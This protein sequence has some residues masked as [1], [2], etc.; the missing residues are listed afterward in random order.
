M[1][2][3]WVN[4]QRGDRKILKTEDD[5]LYQKAGIAGLV[6]CLTRTRPNTRPKLEFWVFAA[7]KVI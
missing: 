6:N 5:Y 7:L 4:Y 1:E 2:F 3:N